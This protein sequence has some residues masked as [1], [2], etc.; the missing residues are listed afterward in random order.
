MTRRAMAHRRGL[1]E[2]DADVAAMLDDA[3]RL[4]GDAPTPY[5]PFPVTV[6]PAPL[7]DLVSA[8]SAAIDC[9]AA[10]VALPAIAAAA[11]A[12]GTLRTIRLRRGWDEPAIVWCA[13]VGESGTAKSP[14]IELALR[15]VRR[16]QT[17]AIRAYELALGQYR[18]DEREHERA[19]A[20]WRRAKGND[21]APQ[22]PAEPICARYWCDDVTVEALA[23]RLQHQPRG[24]LMVR[25]ELR[26]WLGSM[27]RYA[28]SRGSDAARWLELFHA[29]PML[30]DRK[31]SGTLYVPR[32]AVSIVGGIQP[33]IL[34]RA[35]TPEYVDSGLAARLLLAMPP[36]RA[37][38][39]TEADVH[40]DIEDS[41]AAAY[42]ALHAL[43]HE[44]DADGEP[45]PVALSLTRAAR[46]TWI[47]YYDAHALETVELDGELAAAWSKLEAYA[48]RLA[49]VVH[50]VRAVT[51]DCAADAVDERSIDA[52]ITLA[53]WF[54]GE[55]RRV[56]A[57]LAQSDDEIDE[58]RAIARIRSRGGTVSVREWQRLRSHRTAGDALTELHEL[59]EAGCGD[60]IDTPPTPHGGRPSR[61][62]RLRPEAGR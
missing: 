54:G 1:A 11:S 25:D 45:Q 17:L 26:T 39:W 61:L 52:G 12:I 38:K 47:A 40:P 2:G 13:I 15:P 33:G 59:A 20:R 16:R 23:P 21:P 3:D 29:R 22:E 55:A 48:A 7:R 49:L 53:R 4:H 5:S 56:Y 58:R 41:V 28:Q 36:R 62:F 43:M 34:R 27:D 51:G 35:L 30:V 8:G 60:L 24:L 14:A 37:R 42:D 6:L 46:A 31:T 19:V 10:Y 50:C 57:L 9:D 18:D 32:A 44:Y